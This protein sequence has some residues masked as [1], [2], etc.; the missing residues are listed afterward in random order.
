MACISCGQRTN[1]SFSGS[2]CCTLKAMDEQTP[3]EKIRN[4][5]EDFCFIEITNKICESLQNDEGINPSVK[6]SNTDCEDLSSLNDLA[7]AKLHNALMV[8]NLCDVDEYKCWLDSLISWQWNIDKA[9]ICAICGLWKNIHDLWADLE[10]IWQNINE[11]WIAI[12]K[13]NQQIEII[14]QQI[15]NILNE[16]SKLWNDSSSI[17]QNLTEI[18]NKIINLQ[19]KDKDLQEQIDDIKK[20]LPGGFSTLVTKQLWFGVGHAGQNITLSESILNFDKVRVSYNVGGSQ[21]S[22]DIETLYFEPD[23]QNVATYS[24]IDYSGENEFR[25]CAGLK[26]T[27]N[28][29][30]VLNIVS[31]KASLVWHNLRTNAI[32]QW[33]T[34]INCT[35]KIGE[36][37]ISRIEGVRKI[38]YL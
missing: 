38:D 22:V 36:C 19:S 11:L 13:I 27:N 37:I 35:G 9:T 30:K 31:S 28:E 21:Y 14:N 5:D 6:H 34:G 26:A 16:I 18:T 24:G 20:K 29:M 1:N 8:L 12:N 2:G 15:S 17:W 7:S 32:D 25:A 3:L 23:K 10:K 33:Y 4:G